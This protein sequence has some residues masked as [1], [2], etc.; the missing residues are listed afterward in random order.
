MEARRVRRFTLQSTQVSLLQGWWSALPDGLSFITDRSEPPTCFTRDF[1]KLSY[2]PTYGSMTQSRV[3]G[4]SIGLGK[5]L[6]VSPRVISAPCH[7]IFALQ[8]LTAVCRT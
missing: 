4:C 2:S 5:I 8:A 3:V 6:K 7:S 1:S